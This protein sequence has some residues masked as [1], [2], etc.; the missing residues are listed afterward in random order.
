RKKDWRVPAVRMKAGREH[1]V[2]LTP[3]AIEILNALDRRANCVFGSVATS[4]PLSNMAMLQLLRG[5]RAGATVHGFRSVFRDWA[6]EQ[7]NFPN[8]VIEMALAHSITDK[9]EAAY[10]R[11]DLFEK[12]RKL[13]EQWDRYLSK[14]RSHESFDAISYLYQARRRP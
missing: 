6:A 4:K 7:T 9:V 2:P 3:C 12:R 1:R 5:M 8:E 11:G 14:P 10:R 13:M